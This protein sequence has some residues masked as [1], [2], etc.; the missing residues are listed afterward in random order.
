MEAA[1][2]STAFHFSSTR[3]QMA[4][5]LCL[6]QHHP[7]CHSFLAFSKPFSTPI[8][9]VVNGVFHPDTASVLSQFRLKQVS[10]SGD[11]YLSEFLEI[12]RE[13]KTRYL[14]STRPFTMKEK[15]LYLYTFHN[16]GKTFIFFYLYCF[17][18]LLK[19]VSFFFLTE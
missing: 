15:H 16:K 6:T 17:V 9:L 18:I 3:S 2:K 10:V 7:P 4:P 5:L 13:V 8:F 12:R 14:L 11:K 19:F 1:R